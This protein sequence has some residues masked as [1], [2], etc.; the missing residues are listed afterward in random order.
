MSP[1]PT[2][3]QPDATRQRLLDAAFAEIHR[4]GYHASS[5]DQILRAT[6]VTKGA[7]YHHFR[8][9]Q[10]LGLAV[11]DE[12]V[13]PWIETRWRPMLE[14]DRPLQ[15]AIDH[16]SAHADTVDD[17]MLALGCP[18]AN[19][20]QELAGSEP[21]FQQPLFDIFF[22]WKRGLMESVRKSQAIGE[23]RT[24]VDPEDIAVFVIS[25]I[26]G[27]W[28]IA[29]ASRCHEQFRASHRGLVLFLES[30]RA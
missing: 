3:R 28:A 13:R 18:F 4:Y 1:T 6:D 15:A 23:G 19:L 22:E 5:L 16:V 17:D 7:L 12:V 10:A 2:R 14:S 20:V 27:M 11:I 9:K 30:M 25:A 29:K 24:D 26:E 8:N 21:A